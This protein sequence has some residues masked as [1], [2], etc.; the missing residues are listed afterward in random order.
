MS[1][2]PENTKTKVLT[3][4]NFFF[5]PRK[6][7]LDAQGNPIQPKASEVLIKGKDGKPDTIK[8]K[9][10]TLGLPY[11][12]TDDLITLLNDE[13]TAGQLLAF[14]VDLANDKI[15][16][17]AQ[18][19]VNNLIASNI[20]PTQ[21]T[22]KIS[23]LE[24]MRLA[25]QPKTTTRGISKELYAEFKV[26]FITTMTTKFGVSPTGADKAARLIAD[27]KLQN[28]KTQPQYLNAIKAYISQWF[29][30]TSPESQQKFEPIA[31]FFLEKIEGYLATPVES[32]LDAIK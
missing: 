21:E 16:E 12:K 20:E 13:T 11:V 19:Q 2:E 15:Y 32:W 8:R 28:I 27:D 23:E 6:V 5:R 30:G 3:N 18:V 9:Q 24:I 14:M 29:A 1:Q 7:E 10:L 4:D 22:I 17:A 25:V 31:T 26:D